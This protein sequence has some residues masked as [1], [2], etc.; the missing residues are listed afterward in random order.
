[1]S[2]SY[3]KYLSVPP[4]PMTAIVQLGLN[5]STLGLTKCFHPPVYLE[6]WHLA[7]IP[8]VEVAN[9]LWQSRCDSCRAVIY[10]LCDSHRRCSRV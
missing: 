8:R 7:F 10:L 1:M 2:E 9:Y 3:S 6:D 5:I 4:S